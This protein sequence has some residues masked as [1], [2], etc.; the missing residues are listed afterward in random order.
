MRNHSTNSHFSRERLQSVILRIRPKN[1][2]CSPGCNSLARTLHLSSS[3]SQKAP[4]VRGDAFVLIITVGPSSGRF[5]KIRSGSTSRTSPESFTHLPMYGLTS[6]CAWT[7]VY[8]LKKPSKYSGLTSKSILSSVIA[9][10]VGDAGAFGVLS[11][12]GAALDSEGDFALS[13]GKRG[14]PACQT[15]PTPNATAHRTPNDPKSRS[16]ASPSRQTY[17]SSRNTAYPRKTID[18]NTL[19]QIKRAP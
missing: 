17:H 15:I 6:S 1:V 3:N 12:I 16:R 9:V 8:F 19:V 14:N 5:P 4:K 2:I 18:A 10:G 13:A 11:V 7:V